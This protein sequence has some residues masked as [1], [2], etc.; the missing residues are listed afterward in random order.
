MKSVVINQP[1][2]LG[3][4]FFCQKIA[5][6]FIYN[7]YEVYWPIKSSIKWI[8]EYLINSKKV[9]YVEESTFNAPEN[10]ITVTLDAAQNITGGLIMPSKYQ[11]LDID[12]RDWL[13]YFNF[14]RNYQ[15]EDILYYEVLGLT[16]D[17]EYTF[18]NRFYGTPPGHKEYNVLIDETE[19]NV[20]L[21]ITEDF[22]IFDWCKVIENASKISIIDTS[23]NYIID[24]L[25]IRTNKL[26]CYCRH[27]EYTFNQISSLFKK[28]WNYQWN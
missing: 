7:D 20:N 10:C 24:K 1:A 22:T 15:R 27:G 21:K 23:L 9:H 11:I 3:D 26:N 8:D 19:N 12:W 16:D 13:D 14:N 18:V 17:S 5:E 28:K 6:T 4:I 2:G 25:K